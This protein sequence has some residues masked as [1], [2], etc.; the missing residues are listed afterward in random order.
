MH[1]AFR[2]GGRAA[3]NKVMKQQ[4]AVFLKLLVLLVPREMKVGHSGGVILLAGW[5]NGTRCGIPF[6]VRVAG[7]VQVAKSSESSAHVIPATSSR[8]W[9]VSIN[10]RTMA[11]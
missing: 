4:P 3:I 6:L 1:L 9:P 2:R 7:I 10:S 8:R 11:L 5:L